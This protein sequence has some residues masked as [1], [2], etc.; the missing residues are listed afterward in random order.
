MEKIIELLEEHNTWR[1]KCINLIASENT[2]SPY[3]EKYYVSDLMHRYAEGLPFNRYYQGL[4]FVDQIEDLAQ[5]AFMEHFDADFVDIRPISGTLA[6]F[7]VFSALADRGDTIMNLGIQGG[8]HVSHEQAG[9]VGV[10]GLKSY[11]LPFDEVNLK[12]DLLK[13]EEKIL[14]LKPKFIVM[15]GSVITFPQPIREIR[16]ICDQTGT[17]IIYDAAHVFGLITAGKFQNPFEEGADLITASTHKTFPGPQGG[18]IIG[19]NINEKLQKRIQSKVFPGVLS[20][21]HLHR[22]P[23]L[24]LALREMQEFGDE[25]TSQIIKNA[26]ALATALDK[27]GFD[28]LYKDRGFTESHQVV[29]NV[30]KQGGGDPIAKK[31]EEASI[32]LNKN[33]IPGD[34][35]NPSKPKG[36]RIGVQE[37]TRYGMKEEEMQKIA[38]L[39]TAVA[40][41]NKD[42]TE[43]R[44]T[45]EALRNQFQKISYCLG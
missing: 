18:I 12:L 9:A 21:H 44:Q 3:C 11:A 39:I 10:L 1:K 34:T 31:L 23:P 43:I 35:D 37:M 27:A 13:I 29:V 4:K 19:K 22:I 5:K 8:S 41:E 33:I 26:K 38:D 2:M 6:N 45:A 17:K 30:E 42:T 36:L 20:N 25:Y 16:K 32:I 15:G 24:Y 28:V 7:A 40:I 14:E